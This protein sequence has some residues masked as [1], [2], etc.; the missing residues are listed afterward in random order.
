MDKTWNNFDENKKSG[1]FQVARS[2]FNSDIWLDKPAWWIK[3]WIYLIGRANHNDNKLFKRGQFFT[4]LDE[5][6]YKCRLNKEGIKKI[7]TD[8]VVKHLREHQRITTQKTTR[9]FIINIINYKLYQTLDNYKSYTENEKKATQ[10]LHRS[11]TIDKNE[12]NEKNYNNILSANADEAKLTIKQKIPIQEIVDYFFQVKDWQQNKQVYSR[13]VKTAKQLLEVGKD[14][15]IIKQRIDDIGKWAENRN[16]DW[17]L[18][19][20]IKRWFEKEKMTDEEI[21]EHD[22]Q[23]INQRK[24]GN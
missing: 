5:I 14:I 11:Y 20:V 15:N 16:L 6:Y 23:I 17:N 18:D 10:K 4:S 19:T 13:W 7:T 3:V 8:N 1:C 12:K 9:G 21:K 22:L 2:L 24:N